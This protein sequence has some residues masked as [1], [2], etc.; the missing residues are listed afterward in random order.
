[1]TLRM[2][3]IKNKPASS[4]S[5]TTSNKITAIL[6]CSAIT[7]AACAAELAVSSRIGALL[8]VRPF[9]PRAKDC[10]YPASSSTLSTNHSGAVTE[11]KEAG[12]TS[13]AKLNK[14]SLVMVVSLPS[15]SLL[16]NKTKVQL[17]IMKHESQRYAVHTKCCSKHLKRKCDSKVLLQEEFCFL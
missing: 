14:A 7:L 9:S 13:S 11:D 17:L 10:W 12:S 15:Y 1:M 2:V 6:S 4:C 3:L 8:I 5:I 16:Y